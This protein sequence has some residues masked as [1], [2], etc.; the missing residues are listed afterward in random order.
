MN[1]LA[2][3]VLALMNPETTIKTKARELYLPIE[4]TAPQRMSS[5]S[6][7]RNK[8]LD[9]SDTYLPPQVLEQFEQVTKATMQEIHP[10]RDRSL[11]RIIPS[12]RAG[13][14]HI[15]KKK[16]TDP[17]EPVS[18]VPRGSTVRTRVI[19]IRKNPN[20]RR[21]FVQVAAG[22]RRQSNNRCRLVADTRS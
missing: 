10:A 8:M 7:A 12:P 9:S 15:N 6:N 2:P 3:D 5:P 18:S 14:S 16:I 11:G 20:T 4:V 1:K 17:T 19:A 21:T 22:T 13:Q